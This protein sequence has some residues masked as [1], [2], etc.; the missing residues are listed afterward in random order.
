MTG[1]S[2]GRSGFAHGV[3]LALSLGLTAL[4]ACDDTPGAQSPH[5]PLPAYAGHTAEVFDDSIESAAAGISL[6]LHVDPNLDPK[7]RERTQTADA[8]VR[9]RA[10]TVTAKPEESGTR[11]TIG[12]KTVEMV[13]GHFPPGDT[14]EIGVG[15]ASPSSGIMKS[16]DGRLV[17]KSFVGFVRTFVRSDG[18]QEIHFHLAPD[19]KEEVLAVRNAV[20]LAGL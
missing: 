13:T 12:L 19:T 4:V 10:T 1:E 15:P 20:A 18:D 11:F 8:V 3:V 9:V 14:F 6:D 2:M 16:L 7:L 5:R 17:G